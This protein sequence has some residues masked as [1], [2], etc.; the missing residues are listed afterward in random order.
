M[1]RQ[2]GPGPASIDGLRWLSRVGPAP[3]DAWS[4]A[5]GWAP[6]TAR[7]HA[8]RLAR[9]GWIARV[10]RPQ[11]VGSLLYATRVGVQIAELAV[12]PT[13]EPAPTWWAHLEGCAWVAAWLT[14]RHRELVGP[15]ELLADDAWRGELEGVSGRRAAHRPDVIGVVPGRRP[16]GRDRSGAAAQVQGQAACDPC[17]CTLDGSPRHLR[18]VRLRV[19]G[20]G[21]ARACCRAGRGG[22]VERAGAACGLRRSSRGP[23]RGGRCRCGVGSGGMTVRARRH[24]RMLWRFD[25]QIALAVVRVGPGE[26]APA[27]GLGVPSTRVADFI[28]AWR[29]RAGGLPVVSL[30]AVDHPAADWSAC[31]RAHG[32]RSAHGIRTFPRW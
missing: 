23:S 19:P 28:A 32:A 5:M 12:S 13:P 4:C 16:A 6:V 14:A 3:L 15:R 21:D 31:S 18:S 27:G 7:S 26:C 17:A 24:A 9:E 2:L 8:T 22:R 10:R 1:K 30:P 20:R 11:G 29:D 25:G